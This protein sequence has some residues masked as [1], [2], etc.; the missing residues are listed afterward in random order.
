MTC[1]F[2][3]TGIHWSSCNEIPSTGFQLMCLFTC[4]FPFSYLGAVALR[5]AILGPFNGQGQKVSKQRH[6]KP[7]T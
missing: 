1:S 2:T 5:Y 6:L 4:T 7:I 3:C